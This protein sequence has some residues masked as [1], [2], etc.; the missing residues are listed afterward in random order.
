MMTFLLRMLAGRA[1]AESGVGVIL[2]SGKHLAVA[3]KGKPSLEFHS[4]R[5]LLA[6]PFVPSLAFGEA[7]ARGTLIIHNGDLRAALMAIMATRLRPGES[8]LQRFLTAWAVAG[9]RWKEGRGQKQSRHNVH[10]HYDLGNRFYELFL[11]E[12]MQYSCAYFTDSTMSLDAAQEAKKIH[13]SK[14]LMLTKSKSKAMSVLDIGCGWGGMGLTLAKHYATKVRG[15]TLSTQQQKRATARAKQAGVKGVEFILRD[16]RAEKKTYDRIVSVGMFE[17]VGRRQFANYFA[18]VD[19]LL[20]TDGIAL[21]H[22]IGSTKT[23]LGVDPFISKYIFPG[24]YI[25][26]LSEMMKA[27]EA[28]NLRVTDIEVLHDHYAETLRHWHKRF[29]ANRT[30]ALAMFDASFCRIWEFYLVGC[31]LSFRYGSLVVYQLQLAHK[32]EIVPITRDY[33]YKN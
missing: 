24:G 14:K 8:A 27:I 32:K 29:M 15:I 6:I 1:I 16:Y 19:R 25:P 33:L 23:S 22:T 3:K 7:Y 12:D 11:D 9:M 31:E 4:W 10:H 30:K 26:K 21:I 17:H 13:I 2:P 5:T 18:C 20:N 28:T